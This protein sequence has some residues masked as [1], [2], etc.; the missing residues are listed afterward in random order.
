VLALESEVAQSIVER[1]KVTLTGEELSRLV[2]ARYVSPEVYESYLKGETGPQNT[3]AELNLARSYFEGAIRKDPTFAPAYVGLASLYV[4]LGTIFVGASPADVRPKTLSAAKKA[5]E[6]NPDL[7]EGHVLVADVYQ[8]RWQWS[9]AEAEYKRALQ[10]KPNDATAN[11]GFARWLLAQGRTE[12]A[13]AWGWRARELDPFGKTGIEVGWILFCARRYDEAI[14]ELRSMLVIH[15]D[16]A[17]ARWF[18]GFALIGKGQPAE[19]IRE[20]EQTASMTHRNPGSLEV[21]AAAYGYAGRR[22]EALRLI[23]EL[24]LRQKETYVPAG[25][26]INPYLGLRDYDAALTGFERAYTEQSNILQFVKVQPF[27]DPLRGNP[28]FEALVHRIGLK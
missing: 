26:F 11:L 8:K 27:F 5:L 3:A 2:E 16:S 22:A 6:L 28:R 12:E 7:S 15:P 23:E 10:L 19:A 4:Q 13:V 24:K 20:L 14:R 9:D 25:A 1:V 18:L 17:F 21:L